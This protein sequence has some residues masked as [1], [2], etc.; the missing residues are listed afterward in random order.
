[1]LTWLVPVFHSSLI[2]KWFGLLIEFLVE[3]EALVAKVVAID[4]LLYTVG[5]CD[6]FV[7]VFEALTLI[8]HFLMSKYPN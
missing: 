2:Y 8:T 6:V 4:A 1:M 5:T 7:C 3:L